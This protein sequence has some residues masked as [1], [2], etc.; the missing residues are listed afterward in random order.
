MNS[1]DKTIEFEIPMTNHPR[2]NTPFYSALR[3]KY[4]KAFIRRAS[5]N[6]LYSDSTADIAGS[7]CVARSK[8][9]LPPKPKKPN[10]SVTGTP[11]RLQLRCLHGST[12]SLSEISSVDSVLSLKERLAQNQNEWKKIM[13][14]QMSPFHRSKRTA[15][16][17]SR[18]ASVPNVSPLDAVG[19][20]SVEGE[21]RHLLQHKR[22]ASPDSS[23]D[24]AVEMDTVSLVSSPACD[25]KQSE[26][27]VF[28]QQSARS[29]NR[30]P[31]LKSAH[32]K[33]PSG[34]KHVRLTACK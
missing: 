6:S 11:K 33:P 30:T 34:A 3:K 22:L 2:L 31:K 28:S 12:K 21:C 10:Q 26:E 15:G 32:S 13:H 7:P 24:S 16:L 9:S 17:H 20:A 25:K 5:L 14:P 18:S 8:P 4:P 1:E 27:A 19:D 29:R 23:H